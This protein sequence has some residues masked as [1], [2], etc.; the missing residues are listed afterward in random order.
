MVCAALC[1][2]RHPWFFPPPVCRRFLPFPGQPDDASGRP[3]P[4]LRAMI[5]PALRPTGRLPNEG[6]YEALPPF[7]AVLPLYTKTVCTG[8]RLPGYDRD[9]PPPLPARYQGEH[10]AARS[11]VGVPS[12]Q[13]LGRADRVWDETSIWHWGLLPVDMIVGRVLIRTDPS[14]STPKPA[15]QG[16][17]QPNSHFSKSEPGFWCKNAPKTMGKSTETLFDPSAAPPSVSGGTLV[18]LTPNTLFTHRQRDRQPPHQHTTTMRWRV[19]RRGDPD[20]HQTDPWYT[21]PA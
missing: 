16:S 21:G 2:R 6:P 14:P 20:L 15:L 8:H 19:V 9:H 13:G 12:P 5:H 17:L 11:D 18:P 3:P 4:L 1:P 7:G 10:S